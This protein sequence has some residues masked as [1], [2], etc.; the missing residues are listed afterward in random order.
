M[1]TNMELKEALAVLQLPASAL[2]TLTAEAVRKQYLRLALRTHPDKNPDPRAAERFAA[3]G[4]AH[5]AVLAALAADAA[6]HDEQRRT[7]TLLELLLRALAGEDVEAELRAAGEYRPPAAF[8]VDLAVPFDARVPQAPAGPTNAA[9][10][11]SQ[12]DMQQALRE[13]F[14]EEGLTE[15]GDPLAGYEL[16][17]VREV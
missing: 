3:L 14:E 12:P 15:D 10:D 17:L 2:P 7:A 4:A 11:E 13:M 6:A 1:S 5:A 16:P 9:A 8:G